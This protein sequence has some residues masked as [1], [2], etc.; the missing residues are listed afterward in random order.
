[1][2]TRP[3][4]T[5]DQRQ[6]RMYETLRGRIS[7][8]EYPPGMM[9]NES[10]LAAE[11]GVSRTPL[12]RVL[13]QLG[14]E[15]L[16]EIRNGV[17]TTVTDID[18]KTFKDIYDLRILLCDSMGSLSPKPVMAR[19]RETMD[20]LLARAEDLRGE[21][22]VEGYAALCNDLEALVL[23]LIGSRPLREMTDLLYYRVARIWYTF[24]P[25][26]NWDAVVE[27]LLTELR[28]CADALA[29]NDVQAFG[30][31]RATY[32]R[33]MLKKVSRYIASE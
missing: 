17:G 27:E 3:K 28:G 10:V 26:L 6:R 4:E 23:E 8:L 32:L 14:H 15:G 12:R 13:Q 1:M 30:R 2:K 31:V 22:D 21:Q 5:S 24:L 19:H 11:F 16:V 18:M 7:I 33:W 29:A 20:A 9:L 25:N